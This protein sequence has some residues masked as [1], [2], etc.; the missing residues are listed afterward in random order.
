M[1]DLATLRALL[2]RVVDLEQRQ[3]KPDAQSQ[4]N[5]LTEAVIA[6]LDTQL[7]GNAETLMEADHDA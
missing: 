5:L 3:W 6:L 4:I 2:E 1:A 7:F